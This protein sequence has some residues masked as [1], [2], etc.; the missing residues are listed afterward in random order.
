MRVLGVVWDPGNDY[1]Q[2]G[3][4]DVAEEAA[5]VEPT[6]RNIVSTIG[7]FY[8]PL[9][10]LAPVVLRF[11]RLFQKLCEQ[12]VQ[13]DD[14]SE[15]LQDE[16][17][18]LVEDL[19]E[20]GP[21]TIPRSYQHGIKESVTSCSLC[22]FCDASTT[23]FAAVVY[24]VMKTEDETHS[25]FLACKTRVAPLQSIT[26]PRLE[27]LSALLLAQLI[28]TVQSA[29]NSS[30]PEL[31]M[32]C[33]TDSTVALHWIK[34]TSKEWKAFVQNRVVEIRQKIPPDR[35]KHCPGVTNPADL[36][37][38]GSTIMD[39]RASPVWQFGPEWLRVGTTP[40]ALPEMPEECSTELG[41]DSKEAHN[42][43][44][45]EPKCSVG[46]V[47]DSGRFSSFTRLVKV[48][49]YVVRAVKK[50]NSKGAIQSDPLSSND[51]ADDAE[52]LWVKEAQR[53]LVLNRTLKSQLNL[54]RDE[55]ELWRCG[56]RLHNADLPYS[57]KF[58]ILLP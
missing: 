30:L 51:L 50:F 28:T 49:A 25:Q 7:K 15:T 57:T 33:Y 9:G 17:R 2:F 34:G 40:G 8:D 20:C 27:L 16:W 21:L 14:V 32:E 48:T 38:R 47:I 55:D 56:G 23:A 6:K 45:T 46:D 43:V 31:E 37:S 29:L 42:L 41:G 1:L 35:W 39:L 3:V 4:A 58:P 18:A 12:Q 24:L 36:P 22:G 54:F 53:S 13:W 44:T 19:R 52:R 11:K 5:S 26:I 10:F